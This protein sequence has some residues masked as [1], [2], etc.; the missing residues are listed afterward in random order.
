MV[1]RVVAG[2]C[3]GRVKRHSVAFGQQFV[4][5]SIFSRQPGLLARR[6]IDENTAAQLQRP[7]ADHGPDIAASDYAQRVSGG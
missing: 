6:V 1:R 2:A 4:K 7:V 5:R 3:E